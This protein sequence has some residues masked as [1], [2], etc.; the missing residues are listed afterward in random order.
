[1]LTP[2]V[3]K[4]EVAGQQYAVVLVNEEQLNQLMRR[5]GMRQVNSRFGS[6]DATRRYEKLKRRTMAAVIAAARARG[7]WSGLGLRAA[8]GDGLD[9][10]LVQSR[11]AIPTIYTGASFSVTIASVDSADGANVAAAR[12]RGLGL[13]AF[14]RRSPGKYQ[15]YQAMV[16]PFASLDEAEKAQ[17]R[18][19]RHWATAAHGSSSTSRC[20]VRLAAISRWRHPP[21]I[22]GCCSSEHPTG[23][24]SCSNCSRSRVK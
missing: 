5:P 23:C 6:N 4:P 12:V 7:R 1:M 16:G 8:A 10:R 22:Q 3:Q 17:R 2:R 20:A 15:V 18:L 13:P 21:P 9:V 11:P 14:T 19:G 24:R